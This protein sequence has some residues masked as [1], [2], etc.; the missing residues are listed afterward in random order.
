[1]RVPLASAPRPNASFY[2]RVGLLESAASKG[3]RSHPKLNIAGRP[4]AQKCCEGKVKRTLKR[5]SKVLEVVERE[6]TVTFT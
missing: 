2:R 5:E 6:T 3:G 4:I 1:V